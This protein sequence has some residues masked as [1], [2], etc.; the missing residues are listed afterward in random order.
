MADE[1]DK[2]FTQA[3]VDRFVAEE[4]RRNKETIDTLTRERDDALGTVSQVEKERDEAKALVT[5]ADERVKT[6]EGERDTARTEATRFSVALEAGLPKSLA[7]RLQGEDEEA[8]KKDADSL[9]GLLKEQGKREGGLPGPEG[10]TDAP[11]DM[12]ALIR[13]AA[14]RE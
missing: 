1:N 12:N 5:Q 6:I 9:A 7:V 4:R 8:L 13:R 3:D 10:D 14:G 11:D 2:T